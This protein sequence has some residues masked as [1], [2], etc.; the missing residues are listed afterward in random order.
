MGLRRK[1][2]LHPRSLDATGH[3]VVCRRSAR[4]PPAPK[5][6]S[7]ATS[8]PRPDAATVPVEVHLTNNTLGSRFRRRALA[9]GTS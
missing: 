6:R 3:A 7:H 4:A 2:A 9:G 8:A 1:G 5:A